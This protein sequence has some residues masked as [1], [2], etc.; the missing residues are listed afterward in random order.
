MT[1]KFIQSGTEPQTRYA[2]DLIGLVKAARPFVEGF[3]YDPG[4]SDLDN[5]QP[6][7]VQVTLGDWRRLNYFLSGLSSAA[8]DAS[9]E[10]K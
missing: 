1:T 9:K 10:Q 7:H 6:I 2:R 5:E 4:H 8:L 3:T